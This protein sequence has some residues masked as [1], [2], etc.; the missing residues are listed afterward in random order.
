MHLVTKQYRALKAL[1][2][3]AEE[4]AGQDDT[5][6]AMDYACSDDLNAMHRDQFFWKMVLDRMHGVHSVPHQLI[7][8]VYQNP[9]IPHANS[10]DQ[11]IGTPLSKTFTGDDLEKYNIAQLY[12]NFAAY[13]YATAELCGQHWAQV[14]QF[15][16]A[17]ASPIVLAI[18]ETKEEQRLLGLQDHASDDLFV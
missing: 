11:D 15:I 8:R 2:M 3:I 16:I 7:D 6:I 4:F 5:N 18:E 12:L 13:Q 10:Q 9:L 1:Q 17:S 14:Q